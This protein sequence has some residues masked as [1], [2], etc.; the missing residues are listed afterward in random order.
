MKNNFKT[1]LSQ[2]IKTNS[3]YNNLKPLFSFENFCSDNCNS[4]FCEKMITKKKEF[5]NFFLGMRKFSNLTWK[6]I[7]E[8]KQFHFHE[9]DTDKN[10]NSKLKIDETIPLVQFKLPDDKESRIIGYFD[11]KNIFNIVVYDYTHQIYKRK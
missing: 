10:I 5:I 4:Y 8:D 9:I 6:D 2:P 1:L 3:G 11:S 7:K